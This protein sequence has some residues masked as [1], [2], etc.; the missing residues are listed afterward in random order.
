MAAQQRN[1]KKS[2]YKKAFRDKVRNGAI[3]E[4]NDVGKIIKN[5]INKKQLI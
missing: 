4:E 3:R 1:I 5:G 2:L